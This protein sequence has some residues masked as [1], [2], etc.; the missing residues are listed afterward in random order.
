MRGVLLAA[1]LWTT[2]AGC[3]SD[4]DP[5]DID[6]TYLATTEELSGNCG[7]LG[8]FVVQYN[9]GETTT[10]SGC[11]I[12]YERLSEDGC[13]AD[14]AV[15]CSNSADDTRSAGVGS[16]T[17]ED[18]G[19]TSTGTLQITIRTISTGAMQCSSAYRVTYERQ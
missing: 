17:Q 5:E 11:V 14:R 3:G 13:T 7:A 10:E 9:K 6:G 15:T 16:I 18:G 2:A 12:D 4:C 8:S 19:E 1:C